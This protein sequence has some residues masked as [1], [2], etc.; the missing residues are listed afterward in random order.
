MPSISGRDIYLVFEHMSADLY[1]TIYESTLQE[2]HKKF[3]MY[4][5]LKGLFYLHSAKILH[6]DLKP[7]N[8]L[9]T[10]QCQLKICD[11]GLARHL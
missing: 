1:R 11:F 7:S 5:L 9:L 4:Q 3:I 6:R 2:V 8:L 10:M